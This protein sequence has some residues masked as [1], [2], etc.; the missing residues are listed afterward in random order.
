MEKLRDS[1]ESNNITCQIS[2]DLEPAAWKYSPPYTVHTITKDGY[3]L[4]LGAFCS[5][6][7][8]LLIPGEVTH[9]PFVFD[10]ASTTGEI[11]SAGF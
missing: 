10:V 3:C 2:S 1:I 7:D 4:S 11:A 9:F 8:S 5:K 6:I